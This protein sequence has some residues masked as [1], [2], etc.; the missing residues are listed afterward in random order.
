[1]VPGAW[2][3]AWCWRRLIPL[4]EASGARVIAPDLPSLGA[5]TTPPEQVTLE[6]W[7]R[8]VANL[9]E[10]EPGCRLVGHSRAG[11]VISRAAELA[12]RSVGH[13]V[14][15]SAY[16]LCA[17]DSV[18][19]A[20]RRD[21]GSLIAANMIPSRSGITCAVRR[22][23]LREAFY[24]NCSDEDF[25]LAMALLSP[26]PLKPLATPLRVSDGNFGSVPRT[27]IETVRDRAVSLEAQ[28]RMQTALPCPSV[29]TLDT[30]HSSFLS[31]PEALARMLIS[32]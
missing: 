6:S 18:A 32:I 16:L 19:D 21:P 24:G 25:A 7:A 5:D 14:Y 9:V 11:I 8:F 13:L 22:D 27:Y 31:Q 3:G 4:L 28:R 12:P 17:G 10:L 1:L 20:A 29:F 2:H 23:V 30:D 26:E 15:L